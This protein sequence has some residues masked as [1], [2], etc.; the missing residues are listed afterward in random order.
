MMTDFRH[1]ASLCNNE[2]DSNGL[3]YACDRV[4]SQEGL[5]MSV[6]DSV[7]QHKYVDT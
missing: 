2:L 6:A 4:Q 5:F 7:I 3:K 1:M